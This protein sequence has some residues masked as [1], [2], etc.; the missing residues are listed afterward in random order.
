MT[1]VLVDEVH[2]RTVEGD[3]LLMALKE[4]LR[5]RA[6]ERREG[7]GSFEEKAEKSDGDDDTWPSNDGQTA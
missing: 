4:M 6:N 5:R 3:F 1:H 7:G 2:E